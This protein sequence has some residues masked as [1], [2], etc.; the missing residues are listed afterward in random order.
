MSI[1]SIS[2]NGQQYSVDVSQSGESR[3]VNE[4]DLRTA[5]K[6]ITP[7]QL[8]QV[9][10]DLLKSGI[11]I[12]LP[13]GGVVSEEQQLDTL[14]T[15]EGIAPVDVSTDALE[16]MK[17]FQQCATLMRQTERE[18]RTT[19]LSAQVGALLSAADKMKSAADKRLAAGIAQGV[20]GIVGGCVQVGGGAMQI[21]QASQA[22]GASYK[23]VESNASAHAFEEQSRANPAQAQ[24]L[25]QQALD[26][27]SEAGRYNADAM[28]Y[29][30]NAQAFGQIGTGAGP[31]RPRR[32]GSNRS[33]DRPCAGC[34]G[35]SAGTRR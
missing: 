7:G 30:S 3:T 11:S 9:E 2:V 14:A 18:N 28:R 32:R 16:F 19:Q 4:Q 34:A 35:P 8:D 29:S 31:A 21:G 1:T 33:R 23:S 26:A 27:S 13:C 10:R 12:R 15:L 20:M 6:E 22:L 17:I 5:I 25:R 24:A